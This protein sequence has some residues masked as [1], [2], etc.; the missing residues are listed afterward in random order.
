MPSVLPEIAAEATADQHGHDEQLGVA[1]LGPSYGVNALPLPAKKKPRLSMKT[2]AFL[3]GWRDWTRTNDPH[4]VK[5][6]L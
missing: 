3:F 2:R 5:V 4:H 1:A 6:V